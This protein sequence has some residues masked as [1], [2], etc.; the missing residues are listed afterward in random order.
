MQIYCA[1]KP[2]G[3]GCLYAYCFKLNAGAE[4]LGSRA[5]VIPFTKCHRFG[6][7][8]LDVGHRKRAKSSLAVRLKLGPILIIHKVCMLDTPSLQQYFLLAGNLKHFYW[9]EISHALF[10]YSANVSLFY[11]LQSGYTA[12]TGWETL[13][14]KYL[15]SIGVIK[16]TS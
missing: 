15:Y 3:L 14:G 5:P 12:Q 4:K 9:L 11:F 1:A 6:E 13:T 16:L 2:W 7:H 8:D 10:Q